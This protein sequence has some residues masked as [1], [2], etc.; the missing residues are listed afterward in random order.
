M[1][2]QDSIGLQANVLPPAT[3]T[4]TFTPTTSVSSSTFTI[5]DSAATV[6]A[7]A[8]TPV[9]AIRVSLSGTGTG[10]LGVVVN[11]ALD[12]D[13]A[14]STIGKIDFAYDATTK[15][16]SLVDNTGNTA[17]GG[18]FQAVLRLVAYSG[19]TIGNTQSISVNL[20][21]AIYSSENGHYYEFIKYDAA[22]TKTWTAS[23]TAASGKNFLGLTGYLATVTS[24]DENKFMNDRIKEIGWIGGSSAGTLAET[25][26][27]RVWK[28]VTGPETG[29]TFWTGNQTGTAA[30]NQYTNW[31]SGEPNNNDTGS[32]DPSKGNN[33][34]YAHFL[35]NGT[36]NDYS[37]GRGEVQGYWVEYSTKTGLI[38][39]DDGLKGTRKTFSVTVAD[40]NSTG[41]QDPGALD[42][43]FYNPAN[44]QISFAF[45][46]ADNNIVKVGLDLAGDT[47]KLIG[48]GNPA[49]S[50]ESGANWKLISADVDVDQDKF[51]D[52]II[53]SSANGQ[54]VVLFG[55]NRA[56]TQRAYAYSRYAFVESAGQTLTNTQGWTIDF[57]SNTLGANATAGLL[58]RNA[59]NGVAGVGG[60]TTTVDA[61]KGGGMKVVHTPG[62]QWLNLGANSGWT[63]FGDGEFNS[64]ATTRE[65]LWRNNKTDDV[66]VWSYKADRSLASANAIS[67]GGGAVRLKATEW[68]VVGITNVDGTGNDE[69]VWQSG[70][71]VSIWK[72]TANNLTSGAIVTVGAGDRLKDVADVD[73]DGVLDLIGQN[74]TDGTVGFYTLTSTLGKKADRVTYTIGKAAYKPGKG[75]GNAGLE[76]VNVAQ[77]DTIA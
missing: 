44:G 19:G 73:K 37:N 3:P 2:L 48:S 30:Q 27:G 34:P 36:W 61:T 35:G 50:T 75:T 28:W 69:I 38:T 10:V 68:T 71:G 45:V 11:G 49:G 41:T 23:N 46:G 20:G 59:G 74:D 12:S 77:Y 1:P 31:A 21:R 64:D 25:P 26:G 8:A 32:N 16:L 29:T 9:E 17:V 33:E 24:A 70:T 55:E 6:T 54:I 5:L 63:A 18:D 7:D 53:R 4:L 67:F 15:V 56:T 58:W 13:N 42:L 60:L 14:K 22:S 51:K 47:P 72:M 43:V 66:T 52:L 57:A 62:A 65:V 40:P 76:L 39:D